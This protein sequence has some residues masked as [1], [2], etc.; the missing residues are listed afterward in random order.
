MTPDMSTR[1]ELEAVMD[2]RQPVRGA[3]GRIYYV[4]YNEDK[5]R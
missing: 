1:E 4:R 5:E 2:G 3:G